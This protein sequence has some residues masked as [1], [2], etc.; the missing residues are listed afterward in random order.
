M[1]AKTRQQISGNQAED[2]ALDFLQKQGLSLVQR[3]YSCLLGEIDIIMRDN[4]DI[5]F[6]EVRYRHN[7]H[8]GS[9]AESVNKPKQ[10]KIIRT[11]LHFMQKNARLAHHN[12]RFDVVSLASEQ[13]R[14]RIDWIDN[15]FES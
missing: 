13:G 1:T 7:N 8:F 4:D 10:R 9:G 11:A 15:A 5:V 6:V 2:A 3:N 14:F 12:M